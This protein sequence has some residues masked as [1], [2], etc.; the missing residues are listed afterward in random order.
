MGGGGRIARSFQEDQ[1]ICHICT[2]VVSSKGREPIQDV[3]CCARVGYWSYSTARR[4]WQGV[5]GGIRE[6]TST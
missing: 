6:P 5:F 3:Y 1:R 4:G 2:C